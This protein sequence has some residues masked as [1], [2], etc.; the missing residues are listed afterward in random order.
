MPLIYKYSATSQSTI[1]VIITAA[2]LPTPAILLQA[3]QYLIFFLKKISTHGIDRELFSFCEKTVSSS[4][5]KEGKSKV[6]QN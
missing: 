5:G 3:L 2:L 1:A 4:C 6:E